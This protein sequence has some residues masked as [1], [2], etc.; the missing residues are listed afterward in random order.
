M[1]RVLIADDHPIVVEGFK[2]IIGAEPDMEVVGSVTQAGQISGHVRN[3]QAD[4]LTLDI[5]MEGGHFI[6]IIERVARNSSATRVLV[7]SMHDEGVYASRCLRAGATGYLKKDSAVENLVS[8]IRQVHA[9]RKYVGPEYIQLL[10]DDVQNPETQSV[11]HERLTNREFQ[12]FMLL[13]D[14]VRPTDIARRLSLSPKTISTHRKHILEKFGAESN[15][16]L[17][18]YAISRGLLG[19]DP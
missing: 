17:V 4:V 12:V 19:G 7:V 2:R 8:A 11:P 6:D 3:H 15:A 9:G 18:Q 5:S 10:L 13:A 16:D 1:I 14:G